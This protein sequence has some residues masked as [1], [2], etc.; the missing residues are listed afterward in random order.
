MNFATI[1]TSAKD[2][3]NAPSLLPVDNIYFGRAGQPDGY[4]GFPYMELELQLIDIEVATRQGNGTTLSTYEL[5]IATYNVQDQTGGDT[6][7]DPIEDCQNLQDAIT[8][9]YTTIPYN[10]A[11]HAVP[12][13]LHCIPLPRTIVIEDEQL[14]NGRD[15]YRFSTAYRLLVGE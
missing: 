10:T 8:S 6:T 3:W 15:V 1:L 5:E 2:A 11:W 13:F 7:G 9:I 12:G 4:D 14:F